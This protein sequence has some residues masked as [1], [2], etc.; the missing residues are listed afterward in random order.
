VKKIKIIRIQSRI[1]VGGP[2]IHTRLLSEK[3]NPEKYETILIGGA[4]S[5]NEKSLVND[6][7][8]RGIDCRVIP[9]MGRDIHFFE[10]IISFFKL[11][12]VIKKEKPD[13]VH[14]HTAKAGALGRLAAFF[15]RVP[16]VFHTF[17]GHV[18]HSYFSKFR[19]KVYLLIEKLLAKIST[20]IIVISQSQYDDIVSTYHIT[21]PEKVKIISLGF[22]WETFSTN[23]N[24]SLRLKFNIEPDKYLVGIIGRLVPIKGWDLFIEIVDRLIKDS[25]GEFRF[26]IIGDGFLN[27]YIHEKIKKLNLRNFITMSGWLELK[28][29]VYKE[30]DL[31]LST[32][33]NEGTPVSLIEAL[34]S[35][36][37]VVASNVGGV[38]DVLDSYENTW[39]VNS[40]NPS[41]YVSLIKN[42]AKIK[43]RLDARVSNEVKFRYSNERLLEDIEKLYTN[44][45][46]TQL[47]R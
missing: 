29:S 23:N 11:L 14:T 41:D 4:S 45:F 1:V 30:L 12:K 32:S 26:I 15:A 43:V 34:V 21:K 37:P 44:I 40:R 8:E 2:A 6:L 22:D 38:K 9:E 27:E 25:S 17:H 36:I 46:T 31:V 20:V 16:I 28:S 47:I 24:Q 5:N 10:D 33:L 35:G 7:L 3:L 19:T 13:I 18:F 39:L 42:L